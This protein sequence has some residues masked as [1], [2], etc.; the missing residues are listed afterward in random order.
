MI[1]CEAKREFKLTLVMDEGY[2]NFLASVMS[3]P[4]SEDEDVETEDR[5]ADIFD[6]ITSAMR[7]L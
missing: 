7:G 1:E 4:L 6:A 2:A 5:R 3:S